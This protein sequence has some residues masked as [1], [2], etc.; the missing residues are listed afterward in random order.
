MA[1]WYHCTTFPPTA[2]ASDLGAANMFEDLEFWW[3]ASN[4]V[5][6]VPDDVVVA[7]AADPWLMAALNAGVPVLVAKPRE[8]KAATA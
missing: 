8:G 7:V 4:T 5:D 2:G 6:D 1:S 3:I